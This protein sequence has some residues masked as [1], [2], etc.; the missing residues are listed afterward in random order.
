MTA[1]LLL[2]SAS[3]HLSDTCDV[4]RC[5]P[6]PPSRE[7]SP[8]RGDSRTQAGREAVPPPPPACLQVF[9][10]GSVVGDEDGEHLTLVRLRMTLRATVHA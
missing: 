6:R 4:V 8:A 10:F 5:S 1:L 3:T 9:A 2:A 7:A